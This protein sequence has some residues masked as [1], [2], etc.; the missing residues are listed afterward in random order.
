MLVALQI[1]FKSQH[2]VDLQILLL[3]LLLLLHMV[4]GQGG[5]KARDRAVHGE[6]V[7][8]VIILSP[9]CTITPVPSY[10]PNLC[11]AKFC[12]CCK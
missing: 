5:I 7:F 9:Q 1:F 10:A 6:S 3:L 11:I 2:L 4:M 12:N 8:S